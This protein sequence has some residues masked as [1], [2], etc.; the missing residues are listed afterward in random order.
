M[1]WVQIDPRY[2]SELH[3]IGLSSFDAIV[4]HF[5][6]GMALDEGVF[7][8]AAHLGDHTNVFFKLYSYDRPTA[9]FWKRASKARRE[10]ENYERLRKLG[11]S[12]AQRV[13]V[14]EERDR[15][16]RLK[17][18]FVITAAVPGARTLIDFVR[19]QPSRDIRRDLCRRLAQATRA[20][21]DA[22]FFYYDLVWRNVL[23]NGSG[24]L[25][26]IDCP[27]GG[28]SR[29]GRER[30]KLRDLASL[31]KLASKHCRRTE[32]L[33]FVLE[34]LGKKRIDAEARALIYLSRDYRRKRWP[35]DWTGS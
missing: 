16:G 25:V 13:A 11:V 32:R 35:D 17:R 14:G 20:M 26:F 29:F 6:S 31:D 28:A 30:C 2:E 33:G 1:S 21:H 10:F 23:V 3:A 15:L 34:Y 4:D 9:R 5:T 19:E 7:V 22:N 18:A 24:E 12:V 8:T 27:R